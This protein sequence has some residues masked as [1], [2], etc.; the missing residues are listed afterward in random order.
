MG[1][2]SVLR[3]NGDGEISSVTRKA[4]SWTVFIM[5]LFKL[6]TETDETKKLECHEDT[7]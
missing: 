5:V 6:L 2:F 4:R 7:F 1:A 3:F